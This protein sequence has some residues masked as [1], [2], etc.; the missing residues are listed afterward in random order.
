MP[1][2]LD[3]LWATLLAALVTLQIYARLLW[4][5]LNRWAVKSFP[6]ESLH[7]SKY[8]NDIVIIGDDF[9]FGYGDYITL[10]DLPGL[11]SHLRRALRRQKNLRQSWIIHNCGENMSTSADWLPTSLKSSDMKKKTHFEKVFSNPRYL[12]AEIVLILLGFHDGRARPGR[13][14]ISPE[15]T[16]QN[17]VGIVKVLRNMEKEV[18]ICPVATNN[19][20]AHGDRFVEENLQRNVMLLEWLENNKDPGVHCGP[21]IHRGNFEYRHKSLYY[22][23]MEHF[24]SKGYRKLAGDFADLITNSLVKREFARFA[25]DLL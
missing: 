9:A 14:A 5:T 11:A 25:K 13:P 20:K 1:E 8:K 2:I 22:L 24:S 6:P 4:L 23:D 7:V 15:E 10:G 17:I 19:D 18:W 21:Q 12:A 3:K 16:V